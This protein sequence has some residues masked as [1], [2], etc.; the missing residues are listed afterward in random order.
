[1]GEIRCGYEIHA[2]LNHK[3]EHLGRGRGEQRGDIKKGEEGGRKNHQPM[4]I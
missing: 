4:W 3:K 1:V 2:V